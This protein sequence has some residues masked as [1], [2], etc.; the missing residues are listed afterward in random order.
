L[1]K[2]TSFDQ[3]GVGKET[4]I[5]YYV[6]YDF[7]KRWLLHAKAKSSRWLNC[8]LGTWNAEIF[9]NHNKTVGNLPKGEGETIVF[10]DDANEIARDMAGLGDLNPLDGNAN[11]EMVNFLLSKVTFLIDDHLQDHWAHN[12][13]DNKHEDHNIDDIYKSDKSEENLN[14]ARGLFRQ[15]TLPADSAVPSWSYP[16]SQAPGLPAPIPPRNEPMLYIPN[17][18]K[19]AHKSPLQVPEANQIVL[20]GNY[21][22]LLII[23]CY[24]LN[25][26]NRCY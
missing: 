16:K 25:T 11:F 22:M 13:A 4:K 9:S 19:V 12:E 15:D 21:S 24:M 6:D 18:S 5:Q 3:T 7:Y 2:D 20:Q 26:L 14:H 10:V 23:M 8:L 17:N 1:S